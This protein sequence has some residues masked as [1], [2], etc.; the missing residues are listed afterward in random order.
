L[1]GKK[2]GLL[3]GRDEVG[4]RF[5]REETWARVWGVRKNE[6]GLGTEE[7]GMMVWQEG[8]RN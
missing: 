5:G 1:A 6:L 3:L 8:K 2:E 7:T 4:S